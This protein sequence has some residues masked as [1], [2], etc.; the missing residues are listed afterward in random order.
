ML[1]FREELSKIKRKK[2]HYLE[3]I[4]EDAER[5]LKEILSKFEAKPLSDLFTERELTF[6]LLRKGIIVREPENIN[7]I[8]LHKAYFDTENLALMVFMM[9]EEKF[10]NEGYKVKIV[11]NEKFIVIVKP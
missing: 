10:E 3:S 4:E 7:P 11:S 6:Q 2:L 9:L 5:F 1:N 8:L